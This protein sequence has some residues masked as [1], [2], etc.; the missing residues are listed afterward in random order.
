MTIRNMEMGQRG[1]ALLEALISILIFSFGVLG[2]VGLQAALISN[3][4]EAK[5]RSEAGFFANRL[6]GEIS[7]ADRSSLTSLSTFQSPAGATYTAWYDEIKNA[8]ITNGLLGLPGADTIAPQVTIVGANPNVL[9][10]PTSYDITL[11]VFWQSP[12]QP[13]HQHVVQASVSAD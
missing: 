11:T 8:N 10:L 4:S 7:A 5:Y 3:S 13:Q 12:G 9:G 2:I 1:S 6:L